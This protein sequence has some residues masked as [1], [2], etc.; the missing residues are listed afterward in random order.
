MLAYINGNYKI[1]TNHILTIQGDEDGTMYYVTDNR[2]YRQAKLQYK[3]PT[4]WQCSRFGLWFNA[5]F[6]D[7]TQKRIYINDLVEYR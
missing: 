6:D 7:G 4:G 2:Q 5:R 1:G 3:H